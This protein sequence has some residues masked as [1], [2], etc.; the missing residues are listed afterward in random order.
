MLPFTGHF[1]AAAFTLVATSA[2][3][4]DSHNHFSSEIDGVKTNLRRVENEVEVLDL[5]VHSY[6]Q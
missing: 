6:A 5:K 3:I 1:V 4:W 2:L